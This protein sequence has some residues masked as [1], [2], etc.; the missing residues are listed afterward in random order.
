MSDVY[1]DGTQWSNAI[2]AGYDRYL[3]YV[4]RSQPIFRG[5]VDKRPVSVT[6]PGSTVTLSIASEFGSL[7]TTPLSEDLDVAA[8]SPPNLSRVTVTVNQYGKANVATLW[9]E[10]LSFLGVDPAIAELLNRSMLDSH[11]ALVRAVCDGA[12]H[13]IGTNGGT[14]KTDANSFA[15]NSVAA[16]DVYS[17]AIARDTVALLRRR[18]VHGRDA[19]DSYLTVIHPD[20][21][22]DVMSDTGWLQP[23]QYVDTASIYQAEVGSYLGSRFLTSPRCSVN[24]NT[25]SVKV[26]NSYTFGAQALVEATVEDP[27]IIIGPQTDRLRRFFTMGWRSLLGWSIFRQEALQIA[28]TSSSIAAL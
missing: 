1:T 19:R 15:V 26:Y 18:N 13:V 24:T 11:D 16:G 3:E 12:T 21:Q 28:K 20:V 8:E 27:R 9:L 6:N 10:K 25:G 14:V 5:M 7:N 2:I 22:V 17:S 23:H 4:L